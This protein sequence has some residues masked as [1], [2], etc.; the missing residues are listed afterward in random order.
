[1]P[2]TDFA[3][4]PPDSGVSAAFHST[5]RRPGSRPLPACSGL[6]LP[7]RSSPLNRR[8]QACPATRSQPGMAKCLGICPHPA[9]RPN[10]TLAGDCVNWPLPGKHQAFVRGHFTQTPAVLK[11]TL[12][13]KKQL[14]CLR[15]FTPPH[16]TVC[17]YY[18][19]V[20]HEESD[21][22]QR[23]TAISD[24]ISTGMMM[25]KFHVLIKARGRA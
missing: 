3:K 9:L 11:P 17:C 8:R 12:Q 23:S 25:F 5:L 6:S 7:F 1:M 10:P 19:H 2:L 24:R 13:D 4:F 22:A 21:D 18:E 20:F 15:L 16:P 14:V